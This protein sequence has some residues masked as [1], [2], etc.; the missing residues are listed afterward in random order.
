VCY[1]ANVRVLVI[2]LVLS[3]VFSGF[4][5]TVHAI[6]LSDCDSITLSGAKN[7]TPVAESGCAKMLQDDE[8]S[9]SEDQRH[10]TLGCGHCCVSY[11]PIT[12]HHTAFNIPVVKFALTV[13]DSDVDDDFI[14]TLKRPPKSLV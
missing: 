4:Q 14:S 2:L 12:D 6:G 3:V 1:T 10:S 9:K 7:S 5:T 8:N 11:F 13:T